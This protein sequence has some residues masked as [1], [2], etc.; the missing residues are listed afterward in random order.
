MIWAAVKM[1]LVLGGVLAILIPLVW[2]GRRMGAG[3]GDAHSDGQVRLLTTKPIAPR[4]YISLVGIG[5]QILV[6]GISE[7]QITLLDKIENREFVEKI[8]T[9]HAVRPGPFSILD[10]FSI[11]RKGLGREHLRIFNGK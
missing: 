9:Q 3:R 2:L 10:H 7:A 5:E 8:E 11:G 4:K 6:L 1:V